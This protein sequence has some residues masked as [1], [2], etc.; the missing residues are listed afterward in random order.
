[1]ARNW[2]LAGSLVKL[3]EQINTAYPNRS[4]VS[5]G[6]IGDEAHA[7]TASDH[8]PNKAG[9][10]TA[11]DITHD[12]VN[13]LDI[14]ELSDKLAS[15]EDER[16]KYLIANGEILIP[17]NGWHWVAYDGSDPHTSHLHISVQGDYDNNKDWK[18]G[19]KMEKFGSKEELA[20][21]YRI[22]FRQEP[23]KKWIEDTWNTGASYKDITTQAIDYA[24]KS[25]IYKELETK[26][27]ASNFKSDTT[28]ENLDK[29]KVLEYITK[30]LK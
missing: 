7:K 11:F 28:V 12:P 3:R 17:A 24:V 26:I 20:W 22:V 6:T 18:I 9:V 25:G 23:T 30:N 4:K 14:N 2:R 10:V 8:N 21:M 1:M 29:E 19:G 13:G 27:N 5:D 15:S 16:I